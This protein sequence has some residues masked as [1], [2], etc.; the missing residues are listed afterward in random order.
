MRRTKKLVVVC[1]SAVVL[2]STV[3]LANALISSSSGSVVKLSAA[4]ASVKL[5]ALENATSV[6]AFDERQNVTLASA[7]AVDA[8]NPGTY[9]SFPNGSATLAAGT[10]V[11]S[12][13]VHS[14]IPARNYTA[15]RQ[16]TVTFANDIIG[17][18]ASTNRLGATDAALGAPGTQYA[19]TT[20]YRGLEGPEFGTASVDDQFTISANRRSLTFDVRT[21][22]IDEI[23]VITAHFNPLVTTISDTPD[24]VQA[25]EDVTYT[26]TVTNNGTSSAPAVQVRDAFP[27][28]T[29]VSATASGGC[30]G[31]MSPV[32][33]TL[34]TI[35]AG[36]SASATIVVT[37]PTSVPAGG[38][39]TNTAS[40]PPGEAP[41]VN[42]PTT[43]VA[44]SLTTTIADAPDPVTAGNDIQY[45]LT[46]QNTGLAPVANV[47]VVD[48]LPAGT[49]LVSSSAPNGCTGTGPLDCS[50]GTLAVNATAQAVLVVTSPSTVP[51]GGTITNSAVASPGSNAA[52]NETTTVEAPQDG[53]SKG[54]VS[55]GG[56]LSIDGDNPATLTLPN[57]GDGAPVVITQGD[58]TFCDGPC[59]GPTTTINDF[60]GYSDPNH[61]ITLVLTYNFTDITAAADAYGA[62]IYKNDDPENPSTG[63]P[64]AQCT[65]Q[66]A[67]VAVPHPCVDAH[68]IAEPAFHEYV[69]TFTIRYISGD[70][71]FGRR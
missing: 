16:G 57:T 46:V 41:L 26:V 67:G 7:V 33:C 1:L 17:V 63:V 58:G 21:Y 10:V 27:G 62:T 68:T 59:E 30:T 71:S 4:P 55:P 50:L 70:P 28:A 31:T 64:V 60:S 61:P 42:E 5:N 52:A 32:T 11:D 43:V 15:R 24:P 2:V 54:F 38:T 3:T 40:S 69:V 8:V 19:G 45:T 53:V 22:L 48:T 47:H 29:L 34:G 56:S 36:G 18:I 20:N 12:H 23:R 25:G 39:I 65:T 14:D 66:G 6:V 13:L 51:E 44:P 9:A 35:A 49:S 37:S